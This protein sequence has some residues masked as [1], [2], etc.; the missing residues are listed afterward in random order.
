V[1]AL[2]E[3]GAIQARNSIDPKIGNLDYGQTKGPRM[4]ASTFANP[5]DLNLSVTQDPELFLAE[6][7]PT[8]A[9]LIASTEV[10][11]PGTCSEHPIWGLLRM[12]IAQQVSTS[13]ACQIGERVLAAYPFLASPT[14]CLF[15]HLQNC[16]HLD[17]RN[18]GPAVASKYCNNRRNC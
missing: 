18:P 3:G 14:D 8:L 5:D 12:V 1:L 6:R 15:R 16:A 9:R 13:V 7:D 10:R 2:V 17:F 4:R 11:W